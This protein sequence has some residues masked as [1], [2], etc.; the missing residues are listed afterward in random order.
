VKVSYHHDANALATAR[1]Y[2]SHD[3]IETISI[4]IPL[5]ADALHAQVFTDVGYDFADSFAADLLRIAR[6]HTS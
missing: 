2:A 1:S 5:L 6:L 4:E 3:I